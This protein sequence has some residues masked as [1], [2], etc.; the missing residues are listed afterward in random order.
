MAERR[1]GGQ[2]ASRTGESREAEGHLRGDRGGQGRGKGSETEGKHSKSTKEAEEALGAR[3]GSHAPQLR[4]QRLQQLQPVSPSQQA[5]K[6][7]TPALP[8][9][10]VLH[11][12]P[13]VGRRKGG[14]HRWCFHS[15]V[16]RGFLGTAVGRGMRG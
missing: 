8:S 13:R 2:R 9:W 10:R 16:W 4:Q 6:V 1:A 11:G 15:A 7:G 5:G 14:I 3:D 12:G